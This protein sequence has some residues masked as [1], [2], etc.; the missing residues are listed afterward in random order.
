MNA[1]QPITSSKRIDLVDAL[2]G[3]AIFGIFM[4]N[5]PG[6]FK[7]AVELIMLPS[8]GNG[9]LDVAAHS[10]IMFFFTGKFF[11]LFSLL[12]GFGFYIFLHKDG[13]PTRESVKLFRKRVFWLLLFGL[14]HV[15]LFWEGDILVYYALFGFLLILFRK[16]SIKKIVVW[17]VIFMLI[18]IVVVGLV[19]LLSILLASNEVALA[20]FEQGNQEQLMATQ[21]LIERAYLAYRSGSYSE[22]ISMNWEQW[23]FMLS[24]ILF[25]YPTCMA[26]FLVGLLIGRIGLF[27]NYQE[28]LPFFKKV[29]WITLPIGIVC[30]LLLILSI[31]NFNPGVIDGWAFIGRTFGIIGG[32]VMMC[33][34]VSGFIMLYSQG[35]FRRLFNGF[36]YVGRMAL[37]NYIT[38]SVISLLLFRSGLFGLFG[39]VEVWQS[40]LLVLVIFSIQIVFSKWW[41]RQF[42]FG[43]LEWLWRSLTYGKIQ[44]MRIK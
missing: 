39:H 29:F 27:A 40:I 7:P 41:L 5:M 37:T 22:V 25:F 4:V 35:T 36:S 3:F 15:I 30:N 24:G 17:T 28:H 26:L 21:D 6:M 19:S 11:V 34:Y 1:L 9:T 2:R 18:P 23:L 33:T 31:V 8:L 32:V 16:S 44:H 42:K 14:L 10:L 20:A 13:E 43:P 38:H 12:F